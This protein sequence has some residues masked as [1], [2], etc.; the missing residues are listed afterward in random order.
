MARGRDADLSEGSGQYFPRLVL[1][2]RERRVLAVRTGLAVQA[3][4]A[5]RA[6]GVF[7]LAGLAVSGPAA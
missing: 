2:E 4:A 1:L 6:G 7:F 3:D 5:F